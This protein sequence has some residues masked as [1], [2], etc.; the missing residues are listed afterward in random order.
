[1]SSAVDVER[2]G[3]AGRDQGRP[4]ISPLRLAGAA[5]V[6]IWAALFWFVWFS[7]RSLLYV[8]NRTSWIVPAGAILFT[9]AFVG[10]VLSLRTEHQEA[11]TTKDSFF[12]AIFVLP[13]V[14]LFA[15][16]TS[17]LGSFAVGKRAGLS[18]GG[19]AAAV[20]QIP[21]TGD[22]SMVNIGGALIDRESMKALVAR[23]GSSSSFTGFVTRE[24]GEAAN[25][26]LLN[27]FV[28]SCCVADAL[29]IQVRVANAP[30]GELKEDDWVRVTGK[31]YPLGREVIVMASD[32][33]KVAKPKHPYLNP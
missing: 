31:L 8:G 16:P 3:F 5:A 15:M 9:V 10:R 22:L 32:V 26:F 21:S 25:E 30:P 17:S 1:M 29:A 27:R 2:I 24:P 18:N 7:G 11:I 20:G 23:A 4:R 28:I 13:A 12:I 14:L 6:G 19:F 33:E